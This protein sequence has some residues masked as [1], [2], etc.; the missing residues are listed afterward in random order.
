ME[1]VI[2]I[3]IAVWLFLALRSIKKNGAGCCKDCASCQ[4]KCNNRKC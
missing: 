2:I 4:A 1:I 3:G